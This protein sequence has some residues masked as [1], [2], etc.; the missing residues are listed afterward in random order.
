MWIH[1]PSTCYPSPREP[2]G[3]IS[4]SEWRSR[5]LAR[6]A[7]SRSK[8]MPARSW[9]RA[10]RKGGWMT[11]LF[12]RIC[13]PSTAELGAELWILS[14]LATRA[15]RSRRPEGAEAQRILDTYGRTSF[16]F[17]RRPEP[18]GSSSRTCA[19]T[20]R[21]GS[22]R[23]GESFETAVSRW[24]QDF[25]RRQKL[26]PRT[27][28]SGFSLWPTPTVMTPGDSVRR[29]LA[30]Y[31]E[32]RLTRRTVGLPLSL[33]VKMWAAGL[34]GPLDRRTLPRGADSSVDH[35]ILNPLFLE[36]MLGWP[37]GWSGCGCAGTE[38]SRSKP[39]AHSQTSTDDSREAA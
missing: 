30:R 6:S 23:C 16:E 22:S 2:G 27:A 12:G 34:S 32:V 37:I 36:A 5:L 3:S 31:R 9:L 7:L 26:V 24:R 21:S 10:W 4:A 13:E 38:S 17:S 15:S 33:A 29:W 18:R 11:R 19:G 28:G 1:L 20:S 39:L 8:P 25:T 35:L 14:L